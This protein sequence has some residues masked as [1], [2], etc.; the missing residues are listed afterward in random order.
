MWVLEIYQSK[1][2]EGLWS[3]SP[4]VFVRTLGC[5][6]RCRYC[7]TVYAQPSG[8]E[9]NGAD[10]SVEEIVGRILL[11][12]L[13]HVV[14]TGGEPMVSPE[15]Q[16][17]TE[18]LKEYDYIITIETAGIADVPVQ[19]DLI[20]ISPKLGN[21]TPVGAPDDPRV[22][23]HEQARSKPDIVQRL[24]D[25]YYHQLKFVIDTPEDLAEIDEYLARLRG[26]EPGRVLLMP[27][28]VDTA[29]MSEKAEWILPFCEEKGYRYCPRMQIVWY[30]NTR[31]T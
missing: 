3:G 1:Q 24:I 15:I 8:C 7:D 14:I 27:Q 17:L 26:V 12:D 9:E 5:P 11:L 19:C 25:R 23:N 6:L 2:G 20:S 13:P 16:R 4:S 29:T 10:L 28:A 21:S 22:R 30:G 18:L 31:R